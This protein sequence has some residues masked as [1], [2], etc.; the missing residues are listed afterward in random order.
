MQT[1]TSKT[2]KK[3]VLLS[4]ILLCLRHG[5]KGQSNYSAAKAGIVADADHT[6][7]RRT[8]RYG[9]RTGAVAPV[10]YN[11]SYKLMP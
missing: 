3:K 8:L 10:C 2:K 11:D 5:N 1:G 6:L 7:G 4:S 9:I